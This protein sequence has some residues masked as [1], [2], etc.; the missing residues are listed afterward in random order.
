MSNIHYESNKDS[1]DNLKAFIEEQLAVATSLVDQSSERKWMEQL[2]LLTVW[3]KS[4]DDKICPI[5]EVTWEAADIPNPSALTE[6]VPQDTSP[7]EVFADLLSK[8][9]ESLSDESKVGSLLRNYENLLAWIRDPNN[10]KEAEDHAKEVDALVKEVKRRRLQKSQEI[11]KS[12]QATENLNE[13]K[14]LIQEVESWNPADKEIAKEI[15]SIRGELIRGLSVEEIRR[16]F[17]YLQ[18]ARRSDLMQFETSLRELEGRKALDPGFF[19]ADDELKIQEAREYFDDLRTKGGQRTSMVAT[20]DLVDTFV[21]YREIQQANTEQ[22]FYQDVLTNRAEVEAELQ[23]LFRAASRSRLQELIST[24]KGMA[25]NSPMAAISYID[26]QLTGRIERVIGKTTEQIDEVPLHSEDKDKLLA[27][28]ESINQEDRPK[29][30]IAKRELE[31]STTAVSLFDRVSHLI[32]SFT[33]FPLA[34]VKDQIRQL[35]EAAS[36]D[37]LNTVELQF[38]KL[39]SD[40]ERLKEMHL[41][42]IPAALEKLRGQLT[43]FDTMLTQD[44]FGVPGY[45]IV[46]KSEKFSDLN[47]PPRPI[48]L[49]DYS[50]QHRGQKRTD[51][52]DAILGV[53]SAVDTIRQVSITVEQKLKEVDRPDVTSAIQEFNT[54]RDR[55]DLAPYRAFKVL[56]QLV[57]QH[58]G[59]IEKRNRLKQFMEQYKYRELLDYFYSNIAETKEF[60][61]ASQT[62]KSEIHTVL[63]EA[64]LEAHTLLLDKYFKSENLKAAQIEMNW[65]RDHNM[66]SERNRDITSQLEIFLKDSSALEEFYLQ[67]FGK[68]GIKQGDLLPTIYSLLPS[69]LSSLQEDSIS[70]SNKEELMGLIDDS[71]TEI[72]EAKILHKLSSHFS[73]YNFSIIYDFVKKVL[74]CGRY[75]VKKK[76]DWPPLSRQHSVIEFDARR[77]APLLKELIKERI[78]NDLSDK[79]RITFGVLEELLLAY[80]DFSLQGDIE[81]DASIEE[82]AKSVAYNLQSELERASLVE[83]LNLWTLMAKIF[84]RSSLISSQLKKIQV[85]YYSDALKKKI[86]DKRWSE[87]MS[88]I[89]NIRGL[90]THTDLLDLQFTFFTHIDNKEYFSVTEAETIL[91]GIKAFGPDEQYLEEREAD[92]IVAEALQ[93]SDFNLLTTIQVLNTPTNL[94]NQKIKE[95]RN[96]LGRRLNNEKNQ[97]L[98]N[99]RDNSDY[100]AMVLTLSDIYTISS[101]LEMDIDKSVS[102]L[103]DDCTFKTQVPVIAEQLSKDSRP[104]EKTKLQSSIK[105]YEELIPTLSGLLRILSDGYNIDDTKPIHQQLKVQRASGNNVY[106]KDLEE[107]NA[108]LI[109]ALNQVRVADKLVYELRD[110]KKWNDAITDS[111]HGI[112]NA[113]SALENEFAPLQD[114]ALSDF[115]DIDDLIKGFQ[116]WKEVTIAVS[117][118]FGELQQENSDDKTQECKEIAQKISAT[119]ENAPTVFDDEFTSSLKDHVDSCIKIRQYGNTVNHI[120]LDEISKLI[121]SKEEEIGKLSAEIK[122]QQAIFEKVKNLINVLSLDKQTWKE[123]LLSTSKLDQEY[124]FQINKFLGDTSNGPEIPNVPVGDPEMVGEVQENRLITKIIGVFKKSSNGKKDSKLHRD[125][126]TDFNGITI[127]D[128]LKKLKDVLQYYDEIQYSTQ[129]EHLSDKAKSMSLEITANNQLAK[130]KKELLL[131]VI[132]VA[133]EILAVVEESK[134]SADEI[135]AM[136]HNKQFNKIAMYLI[137]ISPHINLDDYLLKQKTIVLSKV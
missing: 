110:K 61:N 3:I 23:R 2:E 55:L 131:P 73:R 81:Y 64:E 122:S 45:D 137:E 44:W 16:H 127:E 70:P 111:I 86:H 12:I 99:H 104:Q 117:K 126:E 27:Y 36:E 14:K 54:I 8:V 107:R 100:P 4:E 83:Q 121:G 49:N 112:K 1:Y 47:L 28:K 101:T 123:R 40:L 133:E 72:D 136:R 135:T 5:P 79:K 63:R 67:A 96:S 11:L 120:G 80:Q 95:K 85:S 132:K 42:S 62:D 75:K 46:S 65:L 18:S 57:S 34:N 68:I 50:L 26:R 53:E 125:L 59:L 52:G 17:V 19:S 58:Q 74:Y 116:I 69:L 93:R 33:S 20:K 109:N 6:S 51:L 84:P 119:I 48:K 89:T 94:A 56:E 15:E 22:V 25:S 32:K 108:V 113:W 82:K 43:N 88:L 106:T 76:P 31:L 71:M 90:V 118:D 38:E 102:E 105:R 134:K 78:Q 39:E 60:L 37:R 41:D 91:E 87:A 24:A 92:L 7:H 103:I 9:K 30:D 129:Q 10:V 21:A 124:L 29:E 128:Q 13:K 115:I 98:Q 77:I 97:Q 35:V 130:T 114:A 66:I